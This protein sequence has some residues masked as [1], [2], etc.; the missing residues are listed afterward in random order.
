[1]NE[2]N[3]TPPIEDRVCR[4]QFLQL[5]RNHP[6]AFCIRFL[7]CQQ[8]GT[9]CHIKVIKLA[10]GSRWACTLDI[11]NSNPSQ[12]FPPSVEVNASLT[13]QDNAVG[14]MTA[15]GWRTNQAVASIPA[16]GPTQPPIST[17]TRVSLPESKAA[18]AW[19]W[20]TTHPPSSAEVSLSSN[21]LLT[22]LLTYLLHGAESFLRR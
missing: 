1:M 7:N 4:M 6:A 15:T 22:Y 16:L 5:T 21:H 3:N 10:H 14:I 12:T 20:P 19:S 13:S 9:S 18:C 11:R 8:I 2:R 17:G